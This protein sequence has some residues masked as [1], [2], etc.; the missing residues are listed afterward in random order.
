ML[1]RLVLHA[2]F[3]KLCCEPF[4][5]SQFGRWHI[6]NTRCPGQSLPGNVLALYTGSNKGHN[7]THGGCAFEIFKAIIHL[8]YPGRLNPID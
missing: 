1:Q 8:W 2:K 3:L 4:S 7:F 6:L 5:D